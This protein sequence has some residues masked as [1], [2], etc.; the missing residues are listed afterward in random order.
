MTDTP[1][2]SGGPIPDTLGSDT[3][4][5]GSLGSE[6]PGSGPTGRE[7]GDAANA[8]D[9]TGLPRRTRFSFALRN[10]DT[11]HLG[12]RTLI[13]GIVNV[14]P[15]SFSDGGQH[16][17]PTAALAHAT[18]L[19]AEGADLLD[20]GGESTRPGAAEIPA[21]EQLR[22]VVPLIRDLVARCPATPISIDTRSAA[23]A[24]AAVEAGAAIVN[25][26]SG[27]VHDPAMAA[28][29]ADLRVP[30][31]LMHMRGTPTDMRER[32][33]Y[34]DV[35]TDVVRELGRRLDAA[36]AAGIEHLIA[37]PGLGFAKTSDQSAAL[38]AATARFRA[39]Q[40]PL[41]VGPSRKSFLALATGER[42]GDPA[43]TRLAATIAASALAAALGAHILRV[44]DVQACGDAIRLADIVRHSL[45]SS[46]AASIPPE[47]TSRDGAARMAR[48]PSTA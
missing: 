30:A 15:D 21:A 19:V 28:T 17:S 48:R 43:T 11:L 45:A 38:L 23:V 5:S 9:A 44:H 42:E 26:V 13:M 41:L 47:W 14:T 32:V 8:L 39:L 16:A 33:D 24:R 22:R 34:D 7:P 35:V 25:D 46:S 20:I 18:R 2:I 6:R 1:P 10:G 4:G 12:A 31:I 3:L 36:R 37:D 40:V 27:L 29:V